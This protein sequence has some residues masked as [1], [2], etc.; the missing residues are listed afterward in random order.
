MAQTTCCVSLEPAGFNPCSQFSYRA[1]VIARGHVV[2][3][4]AVAVVHRIRSR[5]WRIRRRCSVSD[6]TGWNPTPRCSGGRC[7]RQNRRCRSSSRAGKSKRFRRCRSSSRVGES[8]IFTSM[9]HGL[10]QPPPPHRVC[11]RVCVC[12]CLFVLAPDQALVA[13]DI[14]RVK[15]ATMAHAQPCSAK[16]A[17]PRHIRAAACAYRTLPQLHYA[18]T[19]RSRKATGRAGARVCV[20]VCVAIV[21]CVA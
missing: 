16:G 1:V 21:R 6:R 18:K 15:L 5:H 17:Y 7:P 14:P 2:N 4:V 9:P 8:K 3:V 20:C 10:S 11:E 12:V 13:L 19:F